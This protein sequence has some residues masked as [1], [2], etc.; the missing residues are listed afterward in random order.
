MSEDKI[1]RRQM[2]AAA[3]VALLSPVAR[4][5]P[6]S[7]VMVSGSAA[8]LAA[9]IAALP[10]LV[11]IAFMGRIL[12]GGRNLG[13]VFEL[14]LG[15]RPGRVLV[16]A[17]SLWLIFYCGFIF[18]S[19]AY[20]FT[21]TVYPSTGGWI[22]IVLSALCC[23]PIAAG[24]FS[25]IARWAMLLRPVLLAVL[26]GVFLIS[27]SSLD[28]RGVFRVEEKDVLSA[29]QSGFTVLNTLSVVCYLGFMEHRCSEAYA[30]RQYLLWALVLLAITEMLCISC[31]GVFGAELTAKLNY[32]FFMLVRD[33]KLSDSFARLEALV[34]ALWIFADAVHVSLLLRIASGNLARIWAGKRRVFA[35][36]ATA[37]AAGA[38]LAMPGDMLGVGLFSEK[39][40]PAGNALIIFALLPAVAAL[41]W[42]RKKI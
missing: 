34:L 38:G 9:P 19:S 3:F 36:F 25:A 12:R 26:A 11:M 23:L 24:R 28:L 31:L 18:R 10:V 15:K 33:L 4:R 40:I 8:W 1:N 17:I 35:L 21:S 6:S 16:L 29:L 7:L 14:S 13:D 2:V 32:P 37:A 5:V 39:I 22:F 30:P 20:R 41:G 27:I 42:L